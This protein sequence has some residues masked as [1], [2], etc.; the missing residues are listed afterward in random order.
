[1]QNDF[2]IN[3]RMCHE[4]A[5]SIDPLAARVQSWRESMLFP[6][7]V[8]RLS[9]LSPTIYDAYDL[10]LALASQ[11]TREGRQMGDLVLNGLTVLC[12][13][14]HSDSLQILKFV[15]EDVGA[16]VCT[17]TTAAEGLAHVR[18]VKPDVLISD[19]QLPD[20]DGFSMLR[21]IQRLGNENICAIVLSGFC[22]ERFRSAATAA[23]YCAFLTK[24]VDHEDLIECILEVCNRS[25]VQTV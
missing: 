23:G 19:L 15:L 24:P 21:E 2:L 25:R 16:R 12:V 4:G 9:A 13:D 14:D 22:N 6:A 7:R 20:G 18:A 11:I 1:V 5:S 8:L 17:A 3:W 10:G